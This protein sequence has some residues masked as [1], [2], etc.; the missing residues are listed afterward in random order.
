M[1]RSTRYLVLACVLTAL[2]SAGC[3][4]ASEHTTAHE[5]G[6]A[7]VAAKRATGRANQEAQ[8]HPHDAGTAPHTH[9]EEGVQLSAT[10]RANLNLQVAEA[11]TQTLEQILKIPG[12]VKAPPDRVAVVTPRLAA[13]IE[14]VYVNVGESVIQGAPLLDLR[15]TEAEKLQVE[16]LRAAKS[17]SILEQSYARTK[18]LT[19]KIVLTE[20]E[21]LQQELIK[22]HGTL[23]TAAAAVERV[24][25]LSDKVVARKELLAAQTEHQHARSAYD[26]ALRKLQ[27]YGVTAEQVHSMINSGITKP[28]LAN[29]GLSPQAAVQ[30]YL[31]LGKPTELFALEA[32]YRQ[33]QAE[34][35]SVKRQL[36]ILGFSAASITAL[37]QRGVPDP[38]LTLTAPMSGAIRARHAIPGAMVDAAEKLVELIDTSVVWVEGD[39]TEH[40]LTAVRPGQKARVRVAAYPE[41]VFTG[42]VRTMGRTVDPD[43]RTVHLWIEVANPEGRLLPEMF[44][45]VTLVTQ[46]ATEALV[47]PLDAVLTEGAE[48]FVFV[49]NGDI[50]VRQSL[51]LGLR[52]DRYVEVREGL[53]PGDRVVVR[54]GYEINAARLAATQRGVGGH[55][56][57]THSH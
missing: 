43:K 8:N 7:P 54:G 11:T 41:A 9:G 53:F 48:Q 36:Q 57:S 40:L 56:H 15:S 50:Y 32:E 46:V 21:Q 20:L 52:D 37:L 10:A 6:A 19:D 31:V 12:V 27:T 17:L 3:R 4:E 34:V 42:T 47:V 5:T 30:K 22:T 16:L 35:E 14:K 18:E 44:A 25:Q 45:D 29:L 13:R 26:A 2:L 33:K 38:L 51:V 23:Q 55:D 24:Q 39:V 28:V 49:E 1:Y